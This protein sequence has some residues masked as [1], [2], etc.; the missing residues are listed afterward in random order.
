MIG[1]EE[2]KYIH[3]AYIQNLQAAGSII[4]FFSEINMLCIFKLN[5]L[6]FLENPYLA[7]FICFFR[8]QTTIK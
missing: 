1:T 2:L 3:Y 4:T 5:I 8:Y 6:A 7:L